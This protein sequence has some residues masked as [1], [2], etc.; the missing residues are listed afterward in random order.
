MQHTAWTRSRILVAAAMV[1]ACSVTTT[2]S[3]PPASGSAG[4][5]VA[6]ATPRASQ[7]VTAA[8]TPSGPT[9]GGLLL[10]FQLDNADPEQAEAQVVYTFDVGTRERHDVGAVGVSEQ[11][12]CPSDVIWSGDRRRAFLF[13]GSYLGAVDLTTDEI[14][15]RP[16]GVQGF[17]IAPSNGGDRLAWVDEFSG[18]WESII[19]A[20]VKGG[21]T[22]RVELPESAWQ[23]QLAWSPDDT[24][25]AITTVLTIPG[26]SF[27]KPADPA[28]TGAACCA[29]V[30]AASAG[31]LACCTPDHGVTA[32]HL[33]VVPLNG[34]PILALASDEAL[35]RHDLEVPNPTVPPDVTTNATL[36]PGRSINLP[37]WAPDGGSVAYV[38]GTC[39]VDFDFREPDKC[40]Y[41]LRIVDVA[42]RTDRLIVETRTPVWS[43][44]WSPDG[45]QIAYLAEVGR[46]GMNAV[47]SLLLVDAA[48]GE[49]IE[50]SDAIGNV[51]WSPDGTWLSFE[52]LN[53]ELTEGDR[54]DL[55]AMRLDGSDLRLIAEHAAGGW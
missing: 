11:T 12:C 14:T 36:E 55:W 19:R 38:Q 25:F 32:N 52:R 41:Q 15:P 46:D 29:R 53:T 28:G 30:L 44:S 33:M 47:T 24:A 40:T 5:S 7:P 20:D 10:V 34:G 27:P 31:I 54:A 4:P 49:P 13:G 37:T 23:T 9:G 51:H 3:A 35:V 18:G 21:Q 42:D 16:A 22:V 17:K 43:L 48:G 6:A 39:E 26:L 1:A 8:P 2:P 45:S 50:V